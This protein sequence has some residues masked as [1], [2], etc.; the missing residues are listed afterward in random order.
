MHTII[1]KQ[2]KKIIDRRSFATER[3]AWAFFDDNADKYTCEY[4][5]NAALNAFRR[6]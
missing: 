2:G 1:L 6:G 4:V 3:E 5:N